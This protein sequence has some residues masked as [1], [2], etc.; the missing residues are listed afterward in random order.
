MGFLTIVALVGGCGLGLL[1]TLMT[2]VSRRY[3]RKPDGTPRSESTLFVTV[4]NG[5]IGFACL[6]VLSSVQ[7][8]LRSDSAGAELL[9][10]TALMAVALGVTWGVGWWLL[11]PP[12][13]GTHR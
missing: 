6:M 4:V 12:G 11:R 10:L 1:F 8:A 7:Y 3:G 9:G 5:A 2:F 13:G